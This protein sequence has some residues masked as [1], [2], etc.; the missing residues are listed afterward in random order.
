MRITTPLATTAV[1]LIATHSSIAAPSPKEWSIS[2]PKSLQNQHQHTNP[3]SIPLT[4]RSSSSR[5]SKESFLRKA[6]AMKNKY[7]A[8]T[9]SNN[10]KMVKKSASVSMTNEEDAEYYG[11][12]S[13]GTPSTSYQV[14]FDTGSADLV[15][16]TNNCDGCESTTDGYDASDSSTSSSSSTTFSITYGSGDASGTLLSDTVSI[17]GYTVSNQTFAACDVMDNIVTG[18]IDGLLG[19]GWQGIASSG[20]VPLLEGLWKDGTLGTGEFGFAF[21]SY[22]ADEITSETLAGGTLTIGGVDTSYYTGSINW[23]SIVQPSGYWSIPLEGVS[24]QGTSLGLTASA[25]VIDTGTS[26]IGAPTSAV[27]EIYAQIEG[28]EEISLS[29]ESGY[30][31][32]PCSTSVNVTFTFGGVNY[33]ISSE[34]FNSGYVD[35]RGTTC[36]GAVFEMTSSNIEWI[37]GE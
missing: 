27:Q 21:T 34:D 16:A 4:K 10:K 14:I 29:G 30:Y 2:S 28:S 17:G 19:M 5:K 6:Q 8:S 33:A 3:L 24:S 26:L 36:L 12:I 9:N 18:D 20:A 32:Y 7:G 25:A 22:S 31:S 15:M 1:A 35:S 13:I 23:I 11:T 37:F